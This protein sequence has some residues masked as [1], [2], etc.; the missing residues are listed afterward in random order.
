MHQFIDKNGCA[1][2]L[3]FQKNSFK[4]KSGHVLVIC[5]YHDSWLLTKHKERGWE[6]PGGKIEPGE[7]PEQAARREVYEETGAYLE[8]L[9]P[10]GEY[11]VFRESDSFVKTIFYGRVS[12]IVSKDDYLE[13]AGPVLE[14]GDLLRERFTDQYSYIMQDDVIEY[15]VKHLMKLGYITG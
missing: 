14:T 5:R 6:F 12:E 7:T 8:S 11:K 1:V 15:S 4:K 13:T 10:I 2:Q 9:I 3:S